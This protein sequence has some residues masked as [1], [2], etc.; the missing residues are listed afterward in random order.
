MSVRLLD[1]S[2]ATACSNRVRALTP[3]QH[4]T[5]VELVADSASLRVCQSTFGHRY[6]GFAHRSGTKVGLEQGVGA[7]R[8]NVARRERCEALALRIAV[9]HI[10]SCRYRCLSDGT[11]LE[12]MKLFWDELEQLTFARASRTLSSRLPTS[13]CTS[14]S[15]VGAETLKA[16]GFA[17]A[18]TTW[19]VVMG[20]KVY[21][22]T[23]RDSKSYRGATAP[24]IIPSVAGAGEVNGRVYLRVQQLQSVQRE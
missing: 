24:Q 16:F 2:L 6:N 18:S 4:A 9:A 21:L 13:E 17:S 22:P 15:K 12:E 1:A 11:Y 7:I 23:P 5:H 8:S 20:S 3:R 10:I 14:T 19:K